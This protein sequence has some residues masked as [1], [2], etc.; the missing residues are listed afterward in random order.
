M[1]QVYD[2][3][4]TKEN[5]HANSNQSLQLSVSCAGVSGKSRLDGFPATCASF[6]YC[7]DVVD[8]ALTSNRPMTGHNQGATEM[9]KLL[10]AIAL[11]SALMLSS[12]VGAYTS[13]STCDKDDIETELSNL[14]ENGAASKIGLKLVY[15][16]S[17]TEVSRKTDELRCKVVA[18]TN[19][20][21]VTGIFRFFNQ[22]GH[23]LVG[24]E[25]GKSK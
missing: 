3:P 8:C 16:K 1:P 12:S 4:T 14:W 11:S 20:A 17:A 2:G 13:L 7:S 10:T 5:E 21:P 6:V 22:D 23:K 19:V 15:I 24:F 18:V 25:P 9:N